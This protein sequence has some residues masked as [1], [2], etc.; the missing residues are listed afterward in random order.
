MDTANQTPSFD[1]LRLPTVKAKTTLS[2]PSIYRLMKAGLFPKPIKIGSRAVAWK[3]SEIEE[4]INSRKRSDI[5]NAQ[6]FYASNS[7]EGE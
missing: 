5:G 7:S 3:S 4:F 1:L 2:E 6:V